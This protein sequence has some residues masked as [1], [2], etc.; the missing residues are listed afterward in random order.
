MKTIIA[1]ICSLMVTMSYAQTIMVKIEG[2]I[3][4]SNSKNIKL[5][6]A[7]SDG[8]F[9]DFGDASLD[10][11]GKFE[12]STK[13]PQS[14]YYVLR[15]DEGVINLILRD[16]SD[17]KVYGDAKDFGQFTNF[18]NSDESA[19]LNSFVHKTAEWIKKRAEAEQKIKA[20]PELAAQVNQEMQTAFQAFQSEFMEFYKRNQNSPAVI[21]TLNVIDASQDFASFEVIVNSLIANFGQSK[22]VQEISKMY[23][24]LK[25]QKDA[26]NMF[27]PGKLAPDFEELMVD[28]K[29]KMK[30]SDLRGKVVLL[31]FWASWCGPCR[32]ENPNVVAV[33]KKYKDKG[34]TVMNVSLD[35][36][37][38]NWKRAIEQDGLIWPNHVSDLNKWN[39]AVGRIYQVNSIPFA[40]LIDKEGKII[41]TN[42]RGPA[43]EEAVSRLLD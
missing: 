3:F 41:D 35:D 5:S 7:K 29:T 4:N 43:L 39:S 24:Q 26:A 37:L 6:Y 33:Y 42:L 25:E 16:K 1:V 20:N 30:L 32:R 21:A 15:V 28:R 34:F 12:M 8:T 36:N 23:A 18:V 10:K 11:E 14:D 19:E 31:D 17:I 27:A 9:D 38:D 40:V 22:K 13:V 2:S